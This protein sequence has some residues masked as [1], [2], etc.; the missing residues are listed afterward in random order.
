[1][2]YTDWIKSYKQNAEMVR[3]KIAELQIT[4]R[5]GI[6]SELINS[7]TFIYNDLLSTIQELKQRNNSERCKMYKEFTKADLKNSMVVKYRNG[8]RRMVVD[9]L[10]VGENYYGELTMY[11]NDLTHKTDNERDIM[12]VYPKAHIFAMLNDIESYFTP[13]WERSEAKEVTMAEIEEKFGCKV[14]IVDKNTD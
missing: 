3:K 12:A 1:M 6:L 4:N 11:N 5:S 14:K 13:L 9:D 8:K 2:D 10:L 7:Y